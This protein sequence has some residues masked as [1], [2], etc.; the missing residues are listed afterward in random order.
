MFQHVTGH[1]GKFSLSIPGFMGIWSKCAH[2]TMKYPSIRGLGLVYIII[3]Q[4]VKEMELLVHATL[5]AVWFA[6][7]FICDFSSLTADI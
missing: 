4:R 6:S 7:R 5:R 3:R 2:H 1:P